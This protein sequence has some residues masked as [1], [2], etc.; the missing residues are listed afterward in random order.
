M[1]GRGEGWKEAGDAA[2]FGGVSSVAGADLF[3][4]QATIRQVESPLSGQ[5]TVLGSV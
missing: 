5:D 1:K 2:E 4:I 3:A